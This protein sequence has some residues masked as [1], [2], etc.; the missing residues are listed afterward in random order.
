MDRYFAS[1]LDLIDKH[2]WAIQGV[3]ATP[4]TPSPTFTYTVGLTAQD[5]PELLCIGL[6][7]TTGGQLLNHIAHYVEDRKLTVPNVRLKHMLGADGEFD[8]VV[9]A[10]SAPTVQSEY[11][12]VAKRLYPLSEVRVWQV[13]IPDLAG[14]FPWEPGYDMPHDFPVLGDVADLTDLDLEAL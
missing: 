10:A 13:I 3:I 6:S 11:V 8:V 1:V 9:I 7:S 4:E 5:F 14:R 12:T 2:G